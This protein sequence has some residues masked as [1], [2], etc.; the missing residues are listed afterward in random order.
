[1]AAPIRKREG[2]GKRVVKSGEYEKYMRLA[3]DLAA[4]AGRAGE[5]PVGCVIVDGTG[6]VLGR[7][8]N[9][10]EETR[11]VTG[12][13]ELEALEA[14]CRARGDWRLDDCAAFVSLEPCPMCAGA[15]LNA[16]I[17]ALVYAAREPV[18]GSAGSVL[19]LF[20]EGYPG[21]TAVTGGV[22]REESEGLLRAFFAQRR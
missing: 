21:K 16:R 13:A 8:R 6:A 19:N 18:T 3:L 15:L 12:H 1:M 17:G 7:G 5:I 11:S 20:A 2:E 22:L 10:R 14:A 9:R 4:E